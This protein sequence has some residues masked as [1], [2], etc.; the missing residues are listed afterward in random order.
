M[1]PTDNQRLIDRWFP[2]GAVDEAAG[3]PAG[4]GRSEKAIF[5]WFAS[6]PIAQARAAVLAALLRDNERLRPLIEAAVRK[7]DEAAISRLREAVAETYPSGSP[8]VLDVFSGRGIIPLE[9]ARFGAR[10]AGFDVSPVA[11]LAGR[12]LADYPLRDWSGERELPFAAASN[13][14]VVLFDPRRRLVADVRRVLAEVGRRLQEAVEP[15]YPR[16]PDG[17]FPWGYLWAVTIPCDGCGRRFPLVGSLVLRHPYGR[18][19]D[20]GQAFRIGVDGDSWYVE[21]LDGVPDQMP[22]FNAT[23]G[24]KGKAARC[25]FCWYIHSLDALK[26]KGAAGEYRDEP[27]L[28]ADLVDDTK[29]FRTLRAEERAAALRTDLTAL[30]RFGRFSAVPD[31]PIPPGNE[32]TVRASGYGYRRYGELMCARQAL[33]FVETARAIRACH[34]EMV[35]AGV[36]EEYAGAL[37]S[38]AAANLVRRLRRATRGS[39]LLTH[40]NPRGTAQNRA[41]AS[42]VFSSESKISFQFD[43]FETGPGGGPGTWESVAQTG[44]QALER[45]VSTASGEPVRFRCGSATALPVRDRT[46]DAVITDPPYYNMIDYSDTSDLFFVWLKR[47]LFDVHPDLFDTEGLQDKADEIIVKRGNAEGEHR[48]KA[49]YESSLARAFAETK[50]VLRPDGHLVVVFGHADPDAWRRLLGA[51]HEAGFV[52]T[53]SWPSR[54]ES[55]NTGVASIKVTITIGCRVAPAERPVATAAQVDVEVAEAVKARVRGWERD[56]LADTDQ[57][58]TAFGPA[59]EVYGRYSK[60]VLPK[61]GIAPI[62]RYL[63]IA[64]MA[65]RD[66]K[67]MKVDQI[68]LETF[69]AVTRFAVFWMRGYGRTKVPKGEARFLAQSDH[70][71]L[72]DVRNGLLAESAGGFKLVLEP[73]SRIGPDSP[74]FDV[75]RAM[76]AAWQK[77]GSEAVATVL[78]DAERTADDKYVRAVIADLLSQLPASDTVAKALTAIQR[79]AQAIDTLSRGLV[80]SRTAEATAQLELSV[81]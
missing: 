43:C 25:P 23:Q 72:D 3:T 22:T 38:Y 44:V 77:G 9:A 59:M 12:L 10:V 34:R 79:N 7:G 45:L 76:A 48:T 27:L 2:C 6:R 18:T 11:T 65:V 62:E 54:T 67:A 70:L 28:A 17:S 74:T 66:A 35:R 53:S 68:P 75:V 5:T 37:T 81:Q 33:Q 13:E 36:S 20:A 51:L 16:N 26:G 56:G 57:L 4:S 14:E 24:K 50:R 78:A 69:D 19:K 32:D 8:V 42:D 58:M 55:A 47:V 41:Q 46:V 29:L 80:V 30:P 73:P 31:E 15:L 71:R 40:G 49:F 61:G 39:T 63:T 52:V 64:R 60:V 1:R 21:V